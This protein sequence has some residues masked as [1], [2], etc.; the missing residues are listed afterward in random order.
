MRVLFDIGH[1][2]HV[3][4]FREARRL[5]IERGAEAVVVA[6]DKE[7]TRALLEAYGIPHVA[8]SKKR[9]GWRRGIELFEWFRI[10][11]REVRRHKV[12][13]VASIGSPAGAWA[14]KT[15]G[16]IHLA[17]NDTETAREQRMLYLPPSARVYTP[18]CLLA[19]FGP[20][21]VRYAG[22]HDLAYLRPERFTPDPSIRHDLGLSD[23]EEYVVL[24]FVSWQATHDWA[25]EKTTSG[26]QRLLVDVASRDRRVFISAEGPL[27]DDLESLRLKIAPHR[28]HDVLAGAAAVIGDGSTTATEAAV[29]GAPSLYISS[30]AGAFGVVKFLERHGL[31]VSRR[32]MSDGVEEARR[33]LDDPQPE[34]C[35]EARARMLDETI[36]VAAFIADRCEEYAG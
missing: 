31:L 25:R 2:G 14:A 36:D 1:P 18:E 33:M 20:K 13:V 30:F 7:V 4:L 19:D 17:F 9:D 5:L 23:G 15:C 24:R 22:L 10:V 28:L 27:P 6:R 8:G 3:H 32:E 21:Q 26:G 11:R 12:D 16:A 34:A 29:L 35:R